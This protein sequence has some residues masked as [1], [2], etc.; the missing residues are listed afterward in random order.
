M[1]REL[2]SLPIFQQKARTSGSGTKPQGDSGD[3][4]YLIFDG[5]VR[6]PES[7][8]EG[9]FYR[10]DNNAF[11]AQMTGSETRQEEPSS[12]KESSAQPEST[13]KTDDQGYI[14]RM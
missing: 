12:V 14:I 6:D 3:S 4:T 1:I 9:K 10:L 11:K 5:Y 13:V 2:F 8:R 7:G